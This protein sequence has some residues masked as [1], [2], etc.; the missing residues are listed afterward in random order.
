MRVVFRSVSCH[1][2]EELAFAGPV[3]LIC[4]FVSVQ[5]SDAFKDIYLTITL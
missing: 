1:R 4:S 5:C 3:V 2:F